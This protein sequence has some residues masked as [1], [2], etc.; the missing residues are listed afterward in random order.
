MDVRIE[1]IFGVIS[2]ESTKKLRYFSCGPSSFWSSIHT[3]RP[4][5]SATDFQLVRNSIVA[6]IFF[7]TKTEPFR[8][9]EFISEET[10]LRFIM[11]S[12]FCTCSREKRVPDASAVEL[13]SPSW[14]HRF[15]HSSFD[16]DRIQSVSSLSARAR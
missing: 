12:V 11:F 5:T 13:S 2:T 3:M 16:S 14:E 4:E 15:C 7:I 10:V 6:S 9:F 1:L 8:A